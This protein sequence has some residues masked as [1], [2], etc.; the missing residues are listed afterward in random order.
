MKKYIIIII[1]VFILIISLILG[2]SFTAK[3]NKVLLLSDGLGASANVTSKLDNASV[4]SS[5]TTDTKALAIECNEYTAKKLID[6]KKAYRF[7]PIYSIKVVIAVNRDMTDANINSYDDILKSG[8]D[9]NISL[10]DKKACYLLMAISKEYYNSESIDDAFKYAKELNKNKNL[11]HA[12]KKASQAPIR[13][14]LDKDVRNITDS[15]IEMISPTEGVLYINMGILE[16]RESNLDMNIFNELKEELNYSD[17]N[18][19]NSHIDNIDVFNKF[20]LDRVKKYRRDILGTYKISGVNGDER[21]IILLISLMILIPWSIYMI[22]RVNDNS[23]KKGLIICITLLLTW[24]IF[25]YL[26]AATPSTTLLRYIWYFNYVPLTVCPA[27]WLIMNIYLHYKGKTSKII[28]TIIGAIS[29]LL[30]V[31]VLTNDLHF[32]AFSFNNGKENFDDRNFG[33][34]FYIICALDFLLIVSGTFLLVKKNYKSTKLSTLL[35]PVIASTAIV[36]Y[37]ALDFTSLSIMSELDY[38]LVITILSFIL[39]ETSLRAGL[40]Q[41]CGRYVSLFNNLSFE[42]SITDINNKH[43]FSTKGYNQEIIL[44]KDEIVVQDYKYRRLKMNNGYLVYKDDLK[45]INNLRKELSDITTELKRNNEALKNKENYT[46]EYYKLLNESNIINE[47]DSEL[48]SRKNEID[49]LV[50]QIDENVDKSEIRLKL[51]RIKV[52]VSYIKQ[53]Y[54]LYINSK[55]NKYMEI[56]N[57][58]LSIRLISTDVKSLGINSGLLCNS[59]EMIPSELC[60]TILDCFFFMLENAYNSN[61]DLFT[62]INVESGYIII[63]GLFDDISI[64]NDYLIDRLKELINN[65][66]VIM[67]I[68]KTDDMQKVLFRIGSDLKC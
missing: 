41:N 55:L 65:K 53:R 49:L 63:F 28:S 27:L 43:I 30:C 37:I 44:D 8:L 59:M 23:L 68:S 16:N 18:S 9:C 29:I 6:A 52:L 38:N 7:T 57:I 67:E 50:N 31:L 13:I 26:K 32:L 5:L 60:V 10:N 34:V 47:L 11:V 14:M 61:T 39:I 22:I 40:I 46:K 62:N 2:F 25:R 36:I 56:Q 58:A 3:N 51:A 19:G 1:S 66:A 54:N 4:V 15:N 12:S 24:L 64:N 33:I 21:S 42:A 20:E 35:G 17:I 45:E 48:K